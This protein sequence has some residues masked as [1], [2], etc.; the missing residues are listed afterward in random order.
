MPFHFAHDSSLRFHMLGFH[1][2]FSAVEYVVIQSVIKTVGDF[3]ESV[4]YVGVE[5]NLFFMSDNA[6]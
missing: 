3:T 5:C 6:V 2:Q 4:P 1:E